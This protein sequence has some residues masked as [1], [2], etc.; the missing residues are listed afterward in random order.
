[1][2]RDERPGVST[3]AVDVGAMAGECLDGRFRLVR[4]IG[5]GGYGAVFEAVQLSVDRT[6]AVKVLASRLGADELS[7]Q[8]FH[9]EAKATADLRHPNT[10]TVFDFGVDDT[11]GVLFLAMEM[12]EGK[13]LQ[14]VVAE[15]GL[16]PVRVAVSVLKAAAGSLQEAHDKG[17]VHRDVKPHNLMC[18][19][20]EGLRAGREP[21]P[22]K[23][24]DFGIAKTVR[25]GEGEEEVDGVSAGGLTK[26]GM[27]VGTPT[28]MAP[29]QIRGNKVDGRVDQYALA[30]TAYWMITGQTP[31][32]GSTVLEIASRHLT[33]PA[34]PLT[35]Y[36]PELQVPPSFEDAL[37]QA[38]A[39]EPGDRFETIEAFAAA[40]EERLSWSAVAVPEEVCS[41]EPVSQTGA[42]SSEEP[43][44]QEASSRRTPS[45]EARVMTGETERTRV[46]GERGAATERGVGGTGQSGFRGLSAVEWCRLA[47]WSVGRLRSVR[48]SSAGFGVIGVVASLYLAGIGGGEEVS[49]ESAFAPVDE[50]IGEA[51]SRSRGAE[52]ADVSVASYESGRTVVWR[53]L[54]RARER[55]YDKQDGRRPVGW[56]GSGV[57]SNASS[58]KPDREEA[59]GSREL[60]TDG[61]QSGSGG[62]EEGEPVIPGRIS[63]RMIPWGELYVDGRRVAR[64]VRAEQVV[65]PGRHRVEMRQGGEV[66]RDVMVEVGRGEVRELVLELE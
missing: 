31:Y 38:L 65:G 46:V 40:C 29:E 55:A 24:I 11:T 8:R 9:V 15:S 36:R 54:W 60:A 25:G 6:C 34:L 16:L 12:L 41:G 47:L 35:S 3:T 30:M 10:V 32:A 19:D 2:T 48:Y 42:E 59:G 61:K 28:Y 51:A 57:T 58:R 20:P 1:M 4:R 50:N 56:L 66:I 23:M 33:E 18:E 14:E 39:K 37:L 17:V 49:V 62:S 7:R 13:T 45:H 64:G 5:E 63:V 27:M 21:V 22:V 44:I 53:A 52:A 26:T 43:V